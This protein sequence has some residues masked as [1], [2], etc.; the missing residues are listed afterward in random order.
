VGAS[1]LFHPPLGSA[2]LFGDA[3]TMILALAITV[4]TI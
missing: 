1:T 3:G 4:L 2:D